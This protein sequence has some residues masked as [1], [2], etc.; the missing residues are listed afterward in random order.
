MHLLIL[1][2]LCFGG[3]NDHSY[4][5]LSGRRRA[6]NERHVTAR[7]RGRGICQVCTQAML[8]AAP[9]PAFNVA[10]A[11]QCKENLLAGSADR[12]ARG[13]FGLESP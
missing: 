6:G 11:C 1:I 3:N 13:R 8:T 12:A 2:Q 9:G 7:S 4:E 5:G 10:A